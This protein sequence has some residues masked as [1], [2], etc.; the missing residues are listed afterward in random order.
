MTSNLTHHTSENENTTL[1]DRLEA[2]Q[3]E[4]QDLRQR[5][6]RTS[7]AQQI[8]TPDHSFDQNTMECK[9]PESSLQNTEVCFTSHVQVAEMGDDGMLVAFNLDH[10]TGTTGADAIE[11]CIPF[12]HRPSTAVP[13]FI[14]IGGKDSPLSVLTNRPPVYVDLKALMP[15]FWHSVRAADASNISNRLI[16]VSTA[17]DQ[18]HTGSSVSVSGMK[19]SSKAMEG[20]LQ[21]IF[22]FYAARQ[23]ISDSGGGAV[24]F[25]DIMRSNTTMSRAE[26]NKFL[27]DMVAYSVPR[28]F[29]RTVFLVANCTEGISD[30]ITSELSFEEFLLSLVKI[31]VFIFH[32]DDVSF[33]D[34]NSRRTCVLKMAEHLN[35]DDPVGTERFLKR[36]A[37]SSAGFGA[38]KL[39]PDASTETKKDRKVRVRKTIPLSRLLPTDKHELAIL[40]GDFL[41]RSQAK[42]KISWQDFPSCY[43]GMH[44]PSM[45]PSK[46]VILSVTV[47][48][49]SGNSMSFLP[50]MKNLPPLCFK[51]LPPH[52]CPPGMDWSLRMQVNFVFAGF[53]TFFVDQF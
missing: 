24:S 3:R 39:P 52:K 46:R 50:K 49:K 29:V 4:N 37:R 9:A 48:N 41:S 34:L 8:L 2:L 15:S 12:R 31:S 36:I 32:D 1:I 53:C 19:G 26:L 25:E 18:S 7:V 47:R 21:Q 51:F 40:V 20:S 33:P 30:E 28:E 14:R 27:E 17:F 11:E 43:I 10:G 23:S 13:P 44:T 22:F 38:W 16:S 42:S 45:S 6:E 5:L 35:L